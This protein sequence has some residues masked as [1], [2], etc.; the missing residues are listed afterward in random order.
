MMDSSC[1]SC[2][3]YG[4]NY[5]CNF[6]SFCRKKDIL[7][8]SPHGFYTWICFP[9]SMSNSLRSL[10][11]PLM[12]RC[13]LNPYPR[14]TTSTHLRQM[15]KYTS[16]KRKLYI[17]NICYDIHTSDHHSLILIYSDIRHLRQHIGEL[18]HSNDYDRWMDHILL[19]Y[20]SSLSRICPLIHSSYD[21]TLYSKY[22][23]LFSRTPIFTNGDTCE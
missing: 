9:P 7:P 12:F 4:N 19:I 16:H 23:I 5:L 17:N 14:T 13:S 21:G 1:N 10:I 2:G 15:A 8:C 3:F 20:D 11:P 18:R 6:V 22:R